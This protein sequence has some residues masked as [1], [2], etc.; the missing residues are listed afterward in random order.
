MYRYLLRHSNL[1]REDGTC[2]PP[3]ISSILKEFKAHIHKKNLN[4]L[5]QHL[6]TCEDLGLHPHKQ[7][8]L[9]K[10]KKN[11]CLSTEMLNEVCAITM[12]FCLPLQSSDIL[13]YAV[14]SG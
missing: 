8:Y 12:F 5:P 6:N 7:C 2:C 13:Y 4:S 11:S 10:G 9:F 1:V 3:P 14:C